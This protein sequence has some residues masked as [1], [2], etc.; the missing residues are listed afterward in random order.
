MQPSTANPMSAIFTKTG[1]IY[2]PLSLDSMPEGTLSKW[3][4]LPGLIGI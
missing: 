1:S 4:V 3:A 2:F